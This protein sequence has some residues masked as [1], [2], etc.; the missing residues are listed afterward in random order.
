M[1]SWRVLEEAGATK[2]QVLRVWQSR[3]QAQIEWL[4][5]EYSLD[6]SVRQGVVIAGRRR[7]LAEIAGVAEAG[8]KAHE[9]FAAQLSSLS[10]ALAAAG[11]LADETAF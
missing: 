9:S 8:E 3:L 10:I 4:N 1:F 6:P 5:A 2:A 7:L 11:L